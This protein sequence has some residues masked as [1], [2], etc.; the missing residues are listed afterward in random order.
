M[1]AHKDAVEVA[2]I[3][4]RDLSLPNLILA[5]PQGRS[6]HAKFMHHLPISTREVL[7][8]RIEGLGRRGVLADWG[9]AVPTTE[10][11]STSGLTTSD[12]PEPP[13]CELSPCNPPTSPIEIPP[14]IGDLDNCESSNYVCTARVGSNDGSTQLTLASELTED[15]DII[16]P[17]GSAAEN[18]SHPTINSSP[19]HRT[20]CP[21]II[22]KL[23]SL[24]IH[25]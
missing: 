19:L 11:L 5:P 8:A 14:E 20:V 25:Y 6:N 4:H 1:I 16:V 21:V 24:G 23:L 10:C 12:S 7:C 17:M 13:A 15:D 18:D 22:V 9:Y 3:L 2:H